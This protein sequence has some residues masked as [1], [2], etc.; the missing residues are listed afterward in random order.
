M[1]KT[2]TIITLAFSSMVACSKKNLKDKTFWSSLIGSKLTKIARTISPSSNGNPV[3]SAKSVAIPDARYAKT[4]H[5]PVT[6]A[7]RPNQLWQIHFFIKLSLVSARLFMHKVREGMK[8]S[9]A[10]PMDGNV[11]VDEFVAGRQASRQAG[12]EL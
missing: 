7:V 10:S 3:M 9:E 5:R 2:F 8:S 11:Q 1:K 6:V 12:Q 4:I